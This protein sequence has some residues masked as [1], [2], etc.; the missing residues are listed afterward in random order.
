MNFHELLK[1]A[2]TNKHFSVLADNIFK[3]KFTGKSIKIVGPFLKDTNTGLHE[4]DDEIIF[5][6]YSLAVTAL[7]KFGHRIKHL[8][9]NYQHIS[10]D[11][12][13]E[14]STLI[15]EQSSNSLISITLQ[16]LN[17]NVLQNFRKPFKSVENLTVTGELKMSGDSLKLNELFPA[18]RRFNLK[19]VN[20]FDVDVLDVEFPKLEHLTVEIPILSDMTE[21]IEKLEKRNP[22]IKELNMYYCTSFDYLKMASENLPNLE[23]LQVNLEILGDEYNGTKIHFPNVKKLATNWGEYDFTKIFLFEELSELDISCEACEG[24]K[25]AAQS[26]HL[27]HLHIA[28][29]SLKDT[30]ILELNEK[31]PNLSELSIDN[32]TNVRDRTIFELVDGNKKL[33]KFHLGLSDDA[34]C[35]TLTQHFDHEWDVKCSSSEISLEKPE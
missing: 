24:A 18:I 21:A 31:L 32:M 27:N 10:N 4:S 8:N 35:D 25:F 6:N 34:L 17:E 11:Q 20:V 26:K 15:A 3:R 5:E 19:D 29:H 16:K 9:I 14:I 7:R 33:K 12:R 2:Q 13:H 22:H 1:M 23:S 28:Q 30:E